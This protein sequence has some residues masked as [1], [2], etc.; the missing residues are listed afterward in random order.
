MIIILFQSFWF[1]ISFPS[2]HFFQAFTTSLVSFH[3]SN[4]QVC[5]NSN[6]TSTRKLPGKNRTWEISIDSPTNPP[7]KIRAMAKLAEHGERLGWMIPYLLWG[8]L[9]NRLGLFNVQ[10]FWCGGIKSQTDNMKRAY[11]H[12][13]V[14]ISTVAGDNENGVGWPT[15]PIGREGFCPGR[16]LRYWKKKPLV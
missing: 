12:K 4:Q 1:K 5:K 9:P 2:A 13:Y 14:I 7:C 16:H 15:R 10:S 8:R 11:I 3:L 6:I